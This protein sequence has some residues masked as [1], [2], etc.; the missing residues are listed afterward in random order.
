MKLIIVAVRI[1]L[2]FLILSVGILIVVSSA[3]NK[4]RE[5]EPTAPNSVEPIQ[6]PSQKSEEKKEKPPV[7]VRGSRNLIAFSSS[8]KGNS[9]G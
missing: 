2:L 3:R 8:N 5:G 4:A 1:Y 6:V 9:H 7:R